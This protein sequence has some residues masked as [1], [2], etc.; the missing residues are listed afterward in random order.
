MIQLCKLDASQSR[1]TTL[2]CTAGED[3]VS[4]AQSTEATCTR[5]TKEPAVILLF[6]DTT[7]NTCRSGQRNNLSDG[8]SHG[9]SWGYQNSFHERGLAYPY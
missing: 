4:G 5:L 1:N 7:S 3:A 6:I 9:C 8:A 2:G